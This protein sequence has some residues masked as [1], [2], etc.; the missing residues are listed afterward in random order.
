LPKLTSPN[1]GVD[2]VFR[3]FRREPALVFD[4]DIPAPEK[5]CPHIN[6]TKPEL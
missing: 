1:P 5:N 4:W 3:T 6:V 2:D